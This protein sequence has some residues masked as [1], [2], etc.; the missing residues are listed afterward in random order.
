MENSGRALLDSGPPSEGNRAAS[1]DAGLIRGWRHRGSLTVLRVLAMILK[2]QQ[3]QRLFIY[4]R[5]EMVVLV[6]L[7]TLVA[8]FAFTLG[9]HLGK[10][11][12][13]ALDTNE[14]NPIAAIEP[15]A[16]ESPS[17]QQ[18]ADNA[19]VIRDFADESLDQAAHDEI[20]KAGLKLDVPRQVELPTVPKDPAA[21]AT[22]TTDDGQVGDELQAVPAALRPAAG[23]KYT[24]QIGSFRTAREA[25]DRA[26]V[27][28][29]AGLKPFLRGAEVKGKGKWYRLYVGG[30]LSRD[31]AEKA[32]ADYRT[33]GLI[34]SF[35]I[36]N[37][38]E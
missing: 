2:M 3:K 21:G 17:P 8:V 37:A 35:I 34:S 33:Q 18:L 22:V 7:G 23:G 36:A 5:K 4:S 9:I 16:E 29:A 20:Q 6:L 11:V 27:L 13:P 30:Y 14:A 19:E 31:E 32:G 15:E 26:Q 38:V 25:T 24:L 10:R 1:L 12:S 28:D